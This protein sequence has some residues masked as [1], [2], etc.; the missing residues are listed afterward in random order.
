MTETGT[1]ARIQF[2]R[3]DGRGAMVFSTCDDNDGGNEVTSVI[4]HGE[5]VSMEAEMYDRDRDCKSR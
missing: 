3:G 1:R 5:H 2:G 4:L